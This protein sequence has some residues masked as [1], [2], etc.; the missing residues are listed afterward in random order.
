MKKI[1][2]TDAIF[3]NVFRENQTADKNPN[4]LRL[5]IDTKAKVKIG[6]LSRTFIKTNHRFLRAVGVTI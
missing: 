4:S 6:N 1:P 3:E 2:Q 5:S